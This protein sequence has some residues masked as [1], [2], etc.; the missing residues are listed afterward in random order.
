MNDELRFSRPGEEPELKALWREVFQDSLGDADLFFETLYT[1]GSAAV[2]IHGGAIVSAAY[3]LKL[4]EYVSGGHWTPC[5]TVYACG[6][7]P[8]H[9]GRGFGG[10]VLE[11]AARSDGPGVCAVRPPEPDL[12]PFCER[13]GFKPVFG[14]S[15]QNCT[16]VG[17]PLNGSAALVTVRGYA[18]LREELLHGQNHID[19]DLKVLDYQEALCRRSG[20]GLFYLVSDK[21]RGCAAAEIVDGAALLLELIVPTGSQ[22]N[23]AAL[24]ARALGCRQFSYRAPL[25]AG[26]A[27]APFA[28]MSSQTPLDAGGTAWFGPALCGDPAPSH[29]MNKI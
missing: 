14:A 25:R 6:T 1:P 26:D 22:Y 24:T 12:F 29:F 9:R 3:T 8:A 5:R 23:A 27:P 20:G 19:L 21:V 4:G 11:L 16:D 28:L 7:A 13:L 18:A 2:Y 15:V 10:Q 17:L